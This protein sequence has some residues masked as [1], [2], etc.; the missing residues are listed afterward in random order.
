[1]V[2]GKLRREGIYVY[3]RLIHSVVQQKLIQHLLIKQYPPIKKIIEG[4]TGSETER[5]SVY[6]CVGLLMAVA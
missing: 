3:I 4:L 6:L 5:Q 2:K 1:M